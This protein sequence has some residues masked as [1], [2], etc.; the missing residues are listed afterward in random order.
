MSTVYLSMPSS[1]IYRLSG[2]WSGSEL[3]VRVLQHRSRQVCTFDYAHPI[4]MLCIVM[5]CYVFG[6]ILILL[7]AIC[8]S[9]IALF[10]CVLGYAMV[11]MDSYRVF[12]EVVSVYS[13]R[14]GAFARVNAS[15][16]ERSI[17]PRECAMTERT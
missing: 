3:S 4:C 5:I 15:M 14:L 10:N 6:V 16:A 2:V 7:V 13:C 1:N 17:V 8:V 9:W 11:D 12:Y